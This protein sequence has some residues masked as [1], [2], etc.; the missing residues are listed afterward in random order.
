MKKT[1][2][3]MA[4]ILIG[5][6]SL[7]AQNSGRTE[8]Y[9]AEDGKDIKLHLY[10]HA[11]LG[12][13]A[14]NNMIYIDPVKGMADYSKEKK[15]DVVFVTHSHGDHLDINTIK[16][17]SK[18]T[19]HIYCDSITSQKINEA[20]V[21]TLKPGE[22]VKLENGIKVEVIPAYN[23]TKEHIQF[24]PKSNKNC[25]YLFNIGKTRI[26]VAGDTEN[27]EEVKALKNIDIAF[28][29]V[30]QPYTMSVNQAIDVIKAIRPKIFYPYHYGN[31]ENSTDMNL[32]E[33]EVKPYTTIKIKDME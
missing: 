10:G 13:E 3:S 15:A 25:G 2:V 8:I 29:P 9:K 31:P 11:S 20:N 24:H 22:T 1:F 18:P 6:T 33:K 12:I 30:N 23:I 19:T 5:L 4:F 16:S 28:L 17:I 27:V 7:L 14:D 21:T 26:Y 32:L